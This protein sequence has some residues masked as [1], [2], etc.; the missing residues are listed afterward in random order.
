[1]KEDFITRTMLE[2]FRNDLIDQERSAATV[3]KYMRD[4]QCFARYIEGKPLTRQAV[5]AYKAELGAQYAVSSANSMLAAVNAFMRFVGRHDLCV[6]QFK[7]QR[8]VYLPENKELTQEEYERLVITA[9]RRGNERLCLILQTI[10]STG[11][12]VSELTAITVEAVRQGEAV[13]LMVKELRILLLNYAKAKEIAAGPIF[14]TRSGKSVSRSAVWRD[15]KKLCTWAG[16]SPQKVYP[17]NLRHLFARTFYGVEKDIAKLADILGHSSVDTTRI[18]VATTG[19][20]HR[21]RMEN[22]HLVPQTKIPAAFAGITC[23]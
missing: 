16:V 3:G 15:M 17:H 5:L 20:E 7:L 4:V 19:M 14:V 11:I 13:V 23:T 6:K 21:R 18:Y 8:Q 22:L 10:C 12:R 9:Y 1:M 2:D